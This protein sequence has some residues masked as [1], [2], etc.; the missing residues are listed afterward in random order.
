VLICINR[1]KCRNKIPRFKDWYPNRRV[2]TRQPSTH[3]DYERSCKHL[4]PCGLDTIAP[5][6]IVSRGAIHKEAAAGQSGD[7]T[8]SGSARLSLVQ[9]PSMTQIAPPEPVLHGN[10]TRFEANSGHQTPCPLATRQVLASSE[11]PSCRSI[12]YVHNAVALPDLSTVCPI[13]LDSLTSSD[14][15]QQSQVSIRVIAR[16]EHAFHSHC[17]ET[18]L[19]Q[20]RPR[21]RESRRVTEQRTGR[22]RPSDWQSQAD[23]HNTQYQER[24][25]RPRCPVCRR[26]LTASEAL[27]SQNV[28]DWRDHF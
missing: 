18:W 28:A 13:C 10:D 11:P 27:D 26:D 16:C 24:L 22:S 12:A 4:T 8:A 1:I 23:L 21:N 9:E 7:G 3:D 14:P 17:L 20:R 5:R 6:L 25:W 15:E 19:L 2:S